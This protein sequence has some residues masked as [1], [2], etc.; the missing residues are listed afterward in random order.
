MKKHAII[1]SC[2]CAFFVF[3]VIIMTSFIV[4]MSFRPIDITSLV[5]PF[6]PL[7]IMNEESTGT[8]IATVDMQSAQLRWNGLRN[9]F[10]VP[11]SVALKNLTFSVTS[12]QFPNFIKEADVTFYPLAL[13]RKSLKLRSITITEAQLSLR[14]DINNHIGF[15]FNKPLPLPHHNKKNIVLDLSKLND[16][17]FEKTFLNWHEE[18]SKTSWQLSDITADIYNSRRQNKSGVVGSASFNLASWN[19]P[20]LLLSLDARSLPYSKKSKNI[21]WSVITNPVN[22]ASLTSISPSLA[23]FNVPVSLESTFS[24]S[25]MNTTEWLLPDSSDFLLHFGKGQLHALGSTYRVEQGLAKLKVLLNYAYKET[26]PYSIDMPFLSLQMTNP[27]APRDPQRGLAF[28]LSSH[29]DGNDLFHPQHIKLKTNAFI[30]HVEFRDLLYFWPAKAAKG[31]R[32]WVTNN[33]TSGF[34]HDLNL[35]MIMEGHKG[36]KSLSL[37]KING[38]VEAQ[39]LTVHWLRPIHPL[40]DMDARL[41]ITNPNSLMIHYGNG[42]QP[43]SGPPIIDKNGTRSPDEQEDL[44]PRRI[45]AGPGTMEIVNLQQKTTTGI[46]KTHLRGDL[47]NI[48]KLLQEPRLHLLSRHPL[49]IGKTQGMT[50]VALNISLPLSKH[51][52]NKNMTISAHADIHN[53]TLGKAVAGHTV[54]NANL[55][56]N[57]NQEN[58]ALSGQ[59]LIEQFPSDIHYFRDFETNPAS[60]IREKGHLALNVTPENIDSSGLKLS[61]FFPSGHSKLFITYFSNTQHH[62]KV[63]LLYDLTGANVTTPIWHKNEG[64]ASSIATS[65]LLEKGHLTDIDKITATGPQLEATGLLD[66]KQPTRTIFTLPHFTV[67]ESQGQGKFIFF[68]PQQ[69]HKIVATINAKKL[70]IPSSPESKDKQQHLASNI[71]IEAISQNDL[72]QRQRPWSIDVTAEQLRFKKTSLGSVK[73]FAKNNGQHVDQLNFEIRNPMPLFVRITPQEANKRSFHLFVPD[74]GEFLTD[75]EI[76]RNIQG[77]RLSLDGLMDDTHEPS[78]FTGKLESSPFVLKKAPTQVKTSSNIPLY[79]WLSSQLSDAENKDIN[80]NYFNMPLTMDNNVVSIHDATAGN[81]SLSTTMS[82]F[83][84]LQTDEIQCRGIVVPISSINKLPGQIPGL[85][86]LFIPEKGG[87]MFS[88]TYTIG[89]TVQKPILHVNPFSLFAPGGLRNM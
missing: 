3:P 1:A 49:D 52:T 37:K 85:G 7:V 17:H 54:H 26:L 77:G 56:L 81:D 12:T 62:G 86:K 64:S 46:I 72:K 27:V 83:V 19:F 8:P 36:I 43:I 48:R 76:A 68:S 63:D 21:R 70:V 51:T 16:I 44:S 82:G 89:G 65:L 67:G 57:V 53:G 38:N 22:P 42:Y 28:H 59:G 60:N 2:F 78:K 20:G 24:L 40:N 55:K 32:L 9:G 13:L 84:F 11:V 87:G 58:L 14:R 35:S 6:L 10:R 15:D 61:R 79:G 31:G 71:L 74:L 75:F 30:P 29:V 23:N 88:I 66:N 69:R 80:V 4:Y 45:D 39:H 33:M 73:L 25:S 50:D 47:G 34:A 18:R 5:K 41:D